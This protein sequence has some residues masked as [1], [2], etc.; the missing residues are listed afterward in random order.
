MIQINHGKPQHEYFTICLP[1]SEIPYG[2]RVNWDKREDFEPLVYEM[3][4]PK[5]PEDIMQA[6][7]IDVWTGFN[8][9]DPE[10]ETMNA[11]AIASYGLP[12]EKLKHVLLKKYKELKANPK[13]EF[14]LLKQL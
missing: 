14:L 6:E 5:D 12:M 2:K 13:V 9:N 1:A 7:L 8:L 11:L 10:G 3:K 4:N